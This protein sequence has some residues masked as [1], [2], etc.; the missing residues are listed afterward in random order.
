[1][2]SARTPKLIVP[3][4]LVIAGT[5]LSSNPPPYG[6]C[7]VIAVNCALTWSAIVLVSSRLWAIP[8]KLEKTALRVTMPKRFQLSSTTGIAFMPL[9]CIVWPTVVTLKYGLTVCGSFCISR[10][11]GT[12][13]FLPAASA[14]RIKP[15]KRPF[16]VTTGSG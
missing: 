15:T 1:M 2:A 10:S 14:G 3:S 8:V 6:F 9:S 5:V 16:R 4:V 11:I 13:G 12:V 7:G